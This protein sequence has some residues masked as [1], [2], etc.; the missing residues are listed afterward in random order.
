MK[1]LELNN[2]IKTN[3]LF[4]RLQ[5][6]DSRRTLE[7]EVYS[8]KQTKEQKKHKNIQKPLRFYVSALDLAFP[9]HDFS[10]ESMNSFD[11]ISI[12]TLKA[13]L[14]FVFFTMYKNNE[15]VAELI[16]YL[17]ILLDQCVDIH[18][19]VFYIFN[20]PILSDPIYNNVFLIHDNKKKRVVIIKLIQNQ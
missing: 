11:N 19:S 9:D 20:K 4:S 8:C 3:I 7:I 1:F 13:E 10:N 5:A 6:F 16:Q 12:E 18:N 2:I 17:N 15:D 14:S